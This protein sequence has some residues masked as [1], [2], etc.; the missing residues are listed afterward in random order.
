MT[1]QSQL[2]HQHIF[3]QML[4][5]HL[6]VGS[7]YADGYRQVV[8][9]AFFLDVGRSQIDGDIGN[10]KLKTSVRHGR[11]DA[12]LAFADC[13]VGKASKVEHNAPGDVYFNGYSRHLEAID[14]CTVCF[15]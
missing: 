5:C 12:V 7:Q 2:A 15:Y 8:A 13:S 3:A 14:G 4:A 6:V 9:A 1:V 11:N 10:G